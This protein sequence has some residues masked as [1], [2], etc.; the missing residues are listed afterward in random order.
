MFPCNSP[1]YFAGTW[2]T[3]SDQPLI[4]LLQGTKRVAAGLRSQLQLTETFGNT[5]LR[6]TVL[7]TARKLRRTV[8]LPE[9]QTQKKYGGS[10]TNISTTSRMDNRPP[11]SMGHHQIVAH[12]DELHIVPRQAQASMP[13]HRRL[14]NRMGIRHNTMRHR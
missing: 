3:L 1:C 6:E 11:T 12:D 5:T 8:V 13:V 4:H 14:K 9:R 10:Q 7:C 2:D